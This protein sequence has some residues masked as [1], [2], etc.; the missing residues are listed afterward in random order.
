MDDITRKLDDLESEY[1]A[2]APEHLPRGG[3]QIRTYGRMIGTRVRE[4]RELYDWSIVVRERI[5]SLINLRSL[6]SRYGVS[7]Q[8]VYR[9]IDHSLPKGAR[10]WASTRGAC[11]QRAG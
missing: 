6:G 7:Y 4:C 5:G 1:M 8:T 11:K 2:T 10:R 3:S 9:Y